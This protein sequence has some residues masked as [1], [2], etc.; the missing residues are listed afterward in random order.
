MIA[1][2]PQEHEGIWSNDVNLLSLPYLFG[3]TLTLL[4]RELI[5]RWLLALVSTRHS[6]LLRECALG[7]HHPISQ[8]CFQ[9]NSMTLS[10]EA[11]CLPTLFLSQSIHLSLQPFYL[12]QHCSSRP[13]QCSL[14]SNS[15]SCREVN[16]CYYTRP[17]RAPSLCVLRSWSSLAFLGPLRMSINW[18]RS[19][20][21]R[22]LIFWEVVRIC[23]A[24]HPCVP[25]LLRH[26]ML[27]SWGSQ[28]Q[29]MVPS[30][31]H[32]HFLCEHQSVKYA[33]TNHLSQV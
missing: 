5:L 23:L 9:P 18:P 20:C 17:H 30:L 28:A 15:R 12:E 29:S 7:Y 10:K 31:N 13:L 14:L 24:C 8:A 33:A 16:Q 6:V 2:S 11:L 4:P 19:R 21:L 3:I 27:L 22:W 1:K 32:L 26:S 25:S